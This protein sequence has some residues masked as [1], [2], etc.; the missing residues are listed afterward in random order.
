MNVSI[1]FQQALTWNALYSSSAALGEA[2]ETLGDEHVD[3]DDE[4]SSTGLFVLVYTDA[5]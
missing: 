2:G 1:L 5:V 4:C 3:D